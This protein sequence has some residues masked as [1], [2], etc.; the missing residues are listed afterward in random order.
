MSDGACALTERTWRS[1]TGWLN[2][3]STTPRCRVREQQAIPPF[4]PGGASILAS[5]CRDCLAC[6]PL[7]TSRAVLAL[8][9]LEQRVNGHG[10]AVTQLKVV[11]QPLDN[12]TRFRAGG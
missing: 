5:Q 3:T 7:S 10:V 8:Q 12:R 11:L 9:S 6:T 2:F 1:R 4:Q